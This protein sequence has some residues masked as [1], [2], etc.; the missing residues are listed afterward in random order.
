MALPMAEAKRKARSCSRTEQSV[1]YWIRVPFFQQR[2]R[3]VFR[4]DLELL[5]R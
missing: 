3:C 4:V 5:M 2:P 1:V